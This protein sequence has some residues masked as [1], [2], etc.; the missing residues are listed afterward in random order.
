MLKKHSKVLYVAALVIFASSIG[1]MAFSGFAGGSAYFIDV[2]D[3]LA[4]PR[5][6]THPVR[7][8]G[9]VGAD[10]IGTPDEGIGV[11]FQLEDNKN[12]AKSLWVTFKGAVPDAFAPGAEV[13]VEGLYQ[14]GQNNF[15]AKKLMTQCPSKYKK[16]ES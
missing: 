4:L 3:A 5:D 12:A 11:R 1:Y 10:G 9:K 7:L 16:R 8:F 14:G 15:A 6:K 13:I 2:A